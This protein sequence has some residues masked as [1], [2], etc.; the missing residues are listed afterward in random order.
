MSRKIPADVEQLMWLIAESGDSNAAQEFERRFPEFRFDLMRRMSTVKSLK[1]GKP[2]ESIPVPVFRPG[3]AAKSTPRWFWMGAFALGLGAMAFGSYYSTQHLLPPKKMEKIVTAPAVTPTAT[4]ESKGPPGS[5]KMEDVQKVG[6]QPS[7]GNHGPGTAG[8]ADVNSSQLGPGDV[9]ALTAE[10]LKDVQ[11]YNKPQ[12][13]K[14][15]DADLYSVIRLIA[16]NGGFSVDIL[17][18]LEN[19]TISVTYSAKGGVDMLVGLGQKYG[20]T[21]IKDGEGKW[22]IV[23]AKSREFSP[24]Q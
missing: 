10:D 24:P 20:F 4:P 7:F 16:S 21:P 23:P 15:E 3:V 22:L 2:S 1:S 12:D 11:K 18:G 9:P 17:P 6:T 13:V 5:M 14:V 19:P 8:D